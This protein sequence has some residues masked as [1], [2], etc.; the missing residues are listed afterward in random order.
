MITGSIIGDVF[1]WIIIIG[2]G[3]IFLSFAFGYLPQVVKDWIVENIF[4]KK[5]KKEKEKK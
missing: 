5:K 1:A 2:L 3:I 4:K